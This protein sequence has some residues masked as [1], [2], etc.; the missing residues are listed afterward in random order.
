[1]ASSRLAFWTLAIGESNADL[2]Y[3]LK[4]DSLDERE[5]GCRRMQR[6][7]QL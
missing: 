5:M 2:Y 7:W 1:M 4:W 6:L 3:N